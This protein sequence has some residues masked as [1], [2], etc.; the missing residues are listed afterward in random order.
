MNS[1]KLMGYLGAFA[2]GAV[3]Y[4][5]MLA[6]PIT[7]TPTVILGALVAGLG[8]AGLLHLPSPL[9][10]GAPSAKDV[11]A[12]VLEGFLATPVP[13]GVGAAAQLVTGLTATPES[14]VNAPPS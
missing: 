10:Q 13:T 7:W 1:T 14:P 6:Q 5:Q 9:L 2:V 12:E 8:A 4:T 3:G 11:G